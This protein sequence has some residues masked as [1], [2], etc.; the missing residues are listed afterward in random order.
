MA[1]LA[2]INE[3]VRPLGRVLKPD[4]W[5]LLSGDAKPKADTIKLVLWALVSKPAF[6]VLGAEA[7]SIRTS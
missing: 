2:K 4:V 1:S 7:T 6:L 5:V 3:L